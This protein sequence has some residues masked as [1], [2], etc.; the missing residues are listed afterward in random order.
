MRKLSDPVIDLSI[1][2]LTRLVAVWPHQ[3]AAA[4]L[5]RELKY[6]RATAVVTDLAEAMAE[7]APHADVVAWVPASRDR[8]RRRGFDQGELLARAIAR[9]LELPVRRALRRTDNVA[10]TA[11]EL[12]GRLAG[13]EFA[14]VG[15]RFVF[16]PR[17]LLV[18]DVFTTGSTMRSAASVLGSRGAGEVIGLVA[19]KARVPDRPAESPLGVYDQLTTQTSGG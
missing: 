5:V 15:R 13:P 8:R 9:R 17:V 18:D 3:G 1:D 7:A 11:R 12:K 6:G 4:E 19:T 10:Q 16:K 2:S 14:P